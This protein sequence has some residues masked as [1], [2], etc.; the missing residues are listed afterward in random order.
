M[1]QLAY[2]V[3]GAV[4]CAV[5]FWAVLQQGARRVRQRG[6]ALSD[7]ARELGFRPCDQRPELLVDRVGRL[8]QSLGEEFVPQ[9]LS[10]VFEKLGDDR[11]EYL[12]EF[13]ETPWAEGPNVR[14]TTYC[15]VHA[16]GDTPLVHVTPR[17]TRHAIDRLTAAG[18]L[19]LATQGDTI[20]VYRADVIVPPGQMSVFCSDVRQLV[21]SLETDSE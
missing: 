21:E 15:V 18:D 10:W 5:V 11:T 2:L 3:C 13:I 7:A 19:T 1:M 14:H 6:A 4:F 12:F 17:T 16:R 20:L 9:S 8:R